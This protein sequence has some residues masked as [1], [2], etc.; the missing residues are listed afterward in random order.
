MNPRIVAPLVFVILLAALMG[1]A[2]P[3]LA[4]GSAPPGD[5]FYAP[6]AALLDGEPGTLVWS[7]PAVGLPALPAA[8]HTELVLY[9]SRSIS[10]EP[11]G[12]SGTVLIPRGSPPQGGWPIVSWSH[13][14]TGAA[15]SCAPSRVTASSPELSAMTRGDV[16]VSGLLQAG[17]AVAR[18]DYEGLGTPG[19]HPYLIG[20]SLAR[21]QIE[22]VHAA[23]EFDPAIG[24]RW[25]AAGHSEGGVSSM[26]SAK[27]A[28]QW[29]SDLDLRAVS[30]IA[31]PTKSRAELQT[32]RYLPIPGMHLSALASLIVGG[33]ITADPEF[34]QMVQAG[35]L[36]PRAASHLDDLE[37]RCFTALTKFDSWG[38]I[39][40]ADFD[41][42]T[43][44]AAE[45]YFYRL[46]DENDPAGVNVGNLPVRIDQG[47]IDVAVPFVFQNSLVARQR[48]R[49]ANVTY[50]LYPTAS[51][52]TITDSAQAGANVVSWLA[53][54]LR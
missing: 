2:N 21:S 4:A 33:Q 39:A 38:G 23:R 12:V 47:M 36:S 53:A 27:Y 16:I 48:L 44:A 32:L 8:A 54:K 6:P 49:G 24:T 5:D 34:R 30:A 35:A 19:A 11:I 31:P 15:D 17:I 3:A 52:S 37:D 51:H 25:A 50:R 40:P 22:I 9:R 18:T 13:V 29:G 42:P 14:T 46:L 1:P 41:G 28:E 26:F 20:R 7:R 43:F 10:G 45:K